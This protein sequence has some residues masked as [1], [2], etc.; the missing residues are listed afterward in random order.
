MERRPELD[1]LAADTV[2]GLLAD[3]EYCESVLAS[4]PP[5]VRESLR[6]VVESEALGRKTPGEALLTGV[7]II[8]GIQRAAATIQEVDRALTIPTAP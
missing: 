1:A 5:G 2:V 3:S 6:S 8:A 4:L 7:I